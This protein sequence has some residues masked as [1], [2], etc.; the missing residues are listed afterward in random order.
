MLNMGPLAKRHGGH[1]DCV[2][3]AEEGEQHPLMPERAGK[4]MVTVPE[5]PVDLVNDI[6]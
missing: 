4:R 5:K 6:G 2:E 3:Q 1:H